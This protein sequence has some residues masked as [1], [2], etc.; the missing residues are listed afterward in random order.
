MGKR[1]KEKL[2][3]KFGG[4]GGFNYLPCIIEASGSENQRL[5]SLVGVCGGR[6]RALAKNGRQTGLNEKKKA[7]Q[8]EKK[9]RKCVRV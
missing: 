3:G 2:R 1:G 6:G 8:K 4:G 9:K 5:R 7:R